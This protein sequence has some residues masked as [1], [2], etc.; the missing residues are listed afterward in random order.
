M[1]YYYSLSSK[2][3]SDGKREVLIR[4]QPFVCGKVLSMRAKSGVFINAVYFDED[5]GVKDLSRKH[6]ATPEI[7]YHKEQA[8]R[9]RKLT[10]YIEGRFN[11]T[12]RRDL[13]SQWL[14]DAVNEYY[15]PDDGSGTRQSFYELANEYISK[16]ECSDG[17]ARSFRVMVRDVA[18][19]EAFIRAT[20]KQRAKYV[21]DIDTITR[22]DIED[23][24]DYLKAESDLAN[25][26]P[27]LFK[28]LLTEYP[29]GVTNSKRTIEQRG[30][31]TIHAI[32]KK[33]RALFLWLAD[34]GKTAN[35]PFDGYKIVAE[36]YGTPIYITIEERNI[37]SETALPTEH[38]RVQRDIFVFQCLIGCRVGD[39]M[40]LTAKNINSGILTYTPHKTKDESSSFAARVPLVDKARELIKR[41]QGADRRGRLFPFITPQRY[42]DAIKAIFTAAGITRPVEVRNSLTGEYELKPINEVA[43]SHLAR[44]T[45]V[46]NL[47]F[48]IKDPAIIGQMSGHVN[49]SKA[50]QRYRNIADEILVDAVQYIK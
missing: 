11:A 14:K 22:D 32:I 25:E 28:R 13:Y 41:Y 46:G 34:E 19:Y 7:T 8:A 1:K 6:L 3:G 16:L 4:L 45:F 17:Y 24:A 49:G 23:F 21:F 37:I 12:D 9:L 2:D 48:R 18:R 43:S 42:N 47:Y 10:A 39:L 50:F 26:Y 38:L 20:D 5:G 30:N 35:R 44:R 29:S 33:L 31:N 27:D 36:Q 15:H 40:N